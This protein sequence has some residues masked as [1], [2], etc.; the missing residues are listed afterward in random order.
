MTRGLRWG[1]AICGSVI[2]YALGYAMPAFS[3][4]PNLY[5]DPLAHRFLFGQRP[6][7]LP[8]GYLGQVLWGIGG[9]LVLGSGTWG[10]TALA[11]TDADGSG[12]RAS[13]LTSMWTIT[14]S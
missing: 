11:R 13:R 5:Y 14:E 1:F 8:M 9:A 6:G 4:V 2:G 12:D 3:R 7:P 10:L